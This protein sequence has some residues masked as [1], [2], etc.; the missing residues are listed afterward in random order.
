MVLST[1]RDAHDKDYDLIVV[2]DLMADPNPETHRLLVEKVLAHQAD[3]ISSAG[4][5]ALL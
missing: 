5:A 4:L 1:V 3:V 2:G